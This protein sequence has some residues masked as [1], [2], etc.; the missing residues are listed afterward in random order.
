[1]RWIGGVETQS[2]QDPH[3]WHG[4][5]QIGGDITSTAVLPRKQEVLAPHQASKPWG[6]AM[7]RRAF[8]TSVFVNQWGL[9]LGELKGYRKPRLSS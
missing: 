7:V 3:P 6:Q 8:I 4:D 9:C 2:S 5:P 1:M